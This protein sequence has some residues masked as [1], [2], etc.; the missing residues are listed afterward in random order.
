MNIQEAYTKMAEVSGI[1]I[2]DTVKVLR[3][4]KSYEM[5]WL[6]GWKEGR[7]D[8]YIGQTG[9]VEEDG[10]NAG[11]NIQF[12]DATSWYF[13]FF[14]LEVVEKGKPSHHFQPFDRVLVR[15]YDDGKWTIEFFER[16]VKCGTFMCLH[17][18]WKECIPYEGNESL[19]NTTDMPE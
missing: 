4:A 2:G 7:M 17:S 19:L 18:S 14:V 15:D 9:I 5:G 13:P 16:K 8:K 10:K 3:K 6:S 1:Q 12:P 11:F